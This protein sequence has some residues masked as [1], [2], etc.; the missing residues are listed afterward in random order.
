MAKVRRIITGLIVLALLFVPA[1]ASMYAAN[2][3]G[4]VASDIIQDHDHSGMPM[5]ADCPGMTDKSSPV[6]PSPCM[7]FCSGLIALPSPVFAVL[8]DTPRL[9]PDPAGV[10]VLLDHVDPPEPHPPKI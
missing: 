9:R 8:K 1:H 6:T 4:A 2:Q 3:I 7:K 10:S 5:Q